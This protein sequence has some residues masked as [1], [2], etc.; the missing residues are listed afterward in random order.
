[1]R[2]S[3]VIQTVLH[4][5]LGVSQALGHEGSHFL[6]LV[7]R[8]ALLV[9]LL[10]LEQ[11]FEKVIMVIVNCVVRRLNDVGLLE[12]VVEL[13]SIRLIRGL[14][15]V[16]IGCKVVRLFLWLL[17][18]HIPYTGSLVAELITIK[19]MY[20]IVLLGQFDLESL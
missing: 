14:E 8:V 2:D 6:I 1:M 13:P 10:I 4:P 9:Y 20:F 7:E 3:F 5:F 19:V 18:D 11:D 15:F 16:D 17:V 12:N